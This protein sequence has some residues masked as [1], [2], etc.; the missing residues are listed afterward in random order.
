MNATERK[1]IDEIVQS[2]AG[3]DKVFVLACQGCPVGCETG[4]QEW[5]DEMRTALD[6]AGIKVPAMAEGNIRPMLGSFRPI[7]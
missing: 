4:G 3:V 5:V 1:P 6:A 7:S 2:L